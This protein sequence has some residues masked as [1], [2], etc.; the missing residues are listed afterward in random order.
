MGLLGLKEVGRNMTA[1]HMQHSVPDN[2]IS[3]IQHV[4]FAK[5]LYHISIWG[6]SDLFEEDDLPLSI[7]AQSLTRFAPGL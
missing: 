6:F 3:R 5:K 1:R 7:F 4:E 2:E